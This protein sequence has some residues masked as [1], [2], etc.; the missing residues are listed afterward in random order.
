MGNDM[1]EEDKP[2]IA[3]LFICYGALAGVMFYIFEVIRN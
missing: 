3:W 2:V 1:H